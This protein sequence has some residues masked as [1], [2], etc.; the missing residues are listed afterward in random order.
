MATTE[1]HQDPTVTAMA[2]DTRLATVLAAWPQD[3]S[4]QACRARLREYIGMPTGPVETRV[5]RM[6]VSR[7]RDV[8]ESSIRHA[9]RLHGDTQDLD[10]A[11]ALVLLAG[12][13]RHLMEYAGTAR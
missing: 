6:T 1:Q 7:A 13:V 2:R 5:R 9:R 8:A 12:S 11:A 4:A 3:A 10:P